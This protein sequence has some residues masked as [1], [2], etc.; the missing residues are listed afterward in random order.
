MFK[1]SAARWMLPHSSNATSTESCL[2]RSRPS[3]EVRVG[4][5]VI[6]AG[7]YLIAKSHYAPNLSEL[8][9]ADQEIT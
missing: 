8:R 7:Y 6:P 2:K 1:R 5:K 4:I 9:I 3:I